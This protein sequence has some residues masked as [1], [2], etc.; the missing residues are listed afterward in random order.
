MSTNKNPDIG[1]LDS[2]GIRE[3]LERL[4]S[5]A[6]FK[7]ALQLQSL[8]RYIVENSINGHED[9]LKERVI[10]MNVFGRKPDYE[11]AD[12]PIVRSR[13]GQL[14]RRLEQFYESGESQGTTVQI[15]IPHGTYRPTFVLRPC[16][17]SGR[18]G[19]GVPDPRPVETSAGAEKAPNPKT[20]SN[21]VKLPRLTRW[22]IR[23]VVGAA[24]ASAI[25]LAAWFATSNLRK[26][27]IDLFWEPIF[28]S[29]KPV[30]IYTGPAEV[31]VLSDSYEDNDRA[32]DSSDELKLPME[33][34]ELHPLA[35]GEVLTAKDLV[36]DKIGY[37]G[38]G[39]LIACA[40]LAVLLA[41]HHRSYVLRSDPDLPFQ[42]LLDSPA[43]LLGAWNNYWTVETTK[44]LPFFYDR[45]ARIRERGGEGRVWSIT[46]QQGVPPPEEYLLVTRHFDSKTGS[47]LISVSG[48]TTCGTRAAGDFVTDPV[49]LKKLAGIPRAA[50]EHKNL[51]ILLHATFVDCTPTSMD[52]LA[53]RYW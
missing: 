32:Q 38:S 48:M 21:P 4:L 10:G 24:T 33:K 28:E 37:S 52:V 1:Q 26:S 11:T 31:Y 36:L 44:D 20:A 7:D 40:K 39:E 29:K 27:E 13:V 43:V 46:F 23:G 2:A 25:L 14:R 16:T 51:E 34:W 47:P 15:V 18:N 9:V 41:S 19:G 49:Q 22:G 35:E 53:T 45:A 17:K 3:S 8:L 42:D 6:L 5:S 50:L 12:D 30:L